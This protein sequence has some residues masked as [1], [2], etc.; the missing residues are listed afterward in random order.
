VNLQFLHCLE[1]DAEGG[2]SILVDGFEVARRFA[3]S[4]PDAYALLASVEIPWRFQDATTDIANHAPVLDVDGNGRL[5]QIRFHTALMGPLDLN[6]EFIE[7]FYNAIRAFG[8][9]LRDPDVEYVF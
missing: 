4:H 2:E 7:P 1:L 6:P 8:Q 3:Q 9:A 5:R